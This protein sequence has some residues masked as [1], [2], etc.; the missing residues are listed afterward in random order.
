MWTFD[1]EDW[2]KEGDRRPARPSDAPAPAWDETMPE[3]QV[4]E[5]IPTRAPR[6]DSVP[7]LP[8]P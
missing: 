5:I 3:L 4:V 1:G 8:T 6:S 7:P 2:E